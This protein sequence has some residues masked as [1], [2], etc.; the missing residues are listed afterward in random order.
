MPHTRDL[1]DEALSKV[2]DYLEGENDKQ[3]SD[4]KPFKTVRRTNIN[5][6]TEKFGLHL[7]KA[8][9]WIKI[10]KDYSK[11]TYS[12][13]DKKSCMEFY[14]LAVRDPESFDRFYDMLEDD[15]SRQEYDWFVKYRVAY[16][17]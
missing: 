5:K 1:V 8:N 11:F 2:H 3:A 15:S 12:Y 14:N 13:F 7:T 10:Q 16:A 9:Q 4:Y 17:F 6:F